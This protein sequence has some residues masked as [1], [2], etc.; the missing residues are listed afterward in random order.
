MGFF[1]YIAG[2]FGDSISGQISSIYE[3]TSVPGAAISVSNIIK[4]VE[5]NEVECYSHNRLRSI[6]SVNRQI[7]MKDL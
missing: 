3:A 1:A 2:G 5:H 7:F 4:L 6:F